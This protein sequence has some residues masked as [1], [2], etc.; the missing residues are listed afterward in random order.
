MVLASIITF[1]I[2]R[3][4]TTSLPGRTGTH[5]SALPAQAESLGSTTTV[6]MAFCSRLIVDCQSSQRDACSPSK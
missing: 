5:S 6:F 1:A 2:A 3:S 4:I